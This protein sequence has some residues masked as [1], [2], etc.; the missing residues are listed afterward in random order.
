MAKMPSVSILVAGFLLAALGFNHPPMVEAQDQ[1]PLLPTRVENVDVTGNTTLDLTLPGGFTLSGSVRSPDLIPVFGGTV[2]ARSEEHVFQ[3]AIVLRDLMPT[4]QI[5]LPPG[6]YHLTVTRL[7]VD[8]FTGTTL[9]INSDVPEAVTIVENT[10]RDLVLPEAPATVA[11]SGTVHSPG[12]LSPQGAI[13]LETLDGR[14]RVIAALN[15]NFS[16]KVPPGVYRVTAT[17][18]MTHRGDVDQTVTL[19]LETITV[20]GQQAFAFTLPA[21]VPLT[22]VVRNQDGSPAVPATVFV[23]EASGSPFRVTGG[24]RIPGDSVNGAY[25]LLL[26]P[27]VYFVAATVNLDLNERGES[28]LTFPDPPQSADVSSP[29]TRDF[30]TPS[31]PPVVT[32]SGTVRDEDGRAVAGALITAR[33]RTITNTPNASFSASSRTSGEGTYQMRVLSGTAYTIRAFPP[34]TRGQ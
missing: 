6:T 15:R 22:G 18:G 30:I 23:S 8:L 14:V 11:I 16:A 4:Y 28:L 3:G 17:L 9:F 7:I 5:E 13:N 32:L 1:R 12:G 20:S 10:R 33:T 19:P 34:M 31:L 26:P 25:L 29:Q 27:A 21:T 24:V 2:V